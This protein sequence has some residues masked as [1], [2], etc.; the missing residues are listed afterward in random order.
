MEV[1]LVELKL[2][3]VDLIFSILSLNAF[4]TAIRI[5]H[6]MPIYHLLIFLLF[7]RF[8]SKPV[9]RPLHLFHLLSNFLIFSWH[10]FY[11][12]PNKFWFLWCLWL[13]LGGCLR[14]WLYLGIVIESS[15][16]DKESVSWL[17][18]CLNELSIGV[19]ISFYF[20]L[21][22][23]PL[24][25]SLRLLLMNTLSSYYCFVFVS[26]VFGGSRPLACS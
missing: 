13:K 12:F 11:F 18:G 2:I 7:F 19:Y 25:P 21:I 17:F 22:A 14:G 10:F 4:R 6:F 8:L 15:F 3:V 23:L 24:V 1:V 26:E 16:E 20:D 5:T 9:N